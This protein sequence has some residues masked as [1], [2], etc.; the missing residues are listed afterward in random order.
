MANFGAVDSILELRDIRMRY[1]SG[2]SC[3]DVLDG[4]DFSV[5]SGE[6]VGL[7][8]PSGTGKTT[9][10]QIAALLERPT[11]GSV[12]V[13]GRHVS[14]LSDDEKA[15]IRLKN[16]GF[17]YQFHNLLPEFTVLENVAIPGLIQRAS[18]KEAY[19]RA[20]DILCHVGLNRRL[21]HR[22]NRLSGGEQQRV[23]IARALVNC[24]NIVIADEPTG[25]LDPHTAESIFDLLID[26]TKNSNSSLLMA[27]HNTTLAA[28]LNRRI[29]IS[30]GTLHEVA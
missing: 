3:V 7:V 22:T 12:V 8:S 9:L 26:L 1:I 16:I 11:S 13:C 20:A 10:L 19:E 23:A 4:I 27:T 21:S 14:T 15:G 2:D 30:N 17:V 5:I 28:K 25:N 29:R 24:P 18:K 6:S